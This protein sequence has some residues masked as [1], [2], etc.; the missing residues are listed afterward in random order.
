MNLVVDIGNTNVKLH[1]FEKD[2][3]TYND[4]LNEENLLSSLKLLSSKNSIQNV[5]VSSVTKSYKLEILEIFKSSKFHDLSNDKLKLPFFN[6]YKDKNSLGQDRI[7]LVSSAV[8][9]FKNQNN[10]IIDLGT[11]ITYDFIDFEGIYHGGAISPGINTRY[12]SL[13]ENTEN[14]P[15]LKYESI[16]KILGLTTNESIHIGVYNG[17]LGEIN[18]YI[19]SLEKSYPKFNVIITGGDSIFLLNKIKNAIFADQ[20]FLAIGLNYI[21]KLNEGD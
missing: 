12:K 11:C 5:I 10:L 13:N 9:Q 7:G 1:L 18:Q 4:S 20:D 19:Y 17:V 16:D 6:S 2:K 14:L 15:L 8:V 21:I 3:K